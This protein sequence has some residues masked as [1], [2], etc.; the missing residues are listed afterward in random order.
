MKPI[1]H[2][3]AA[4]RVPPGTARGGGRRCGARLSGGALWCYGRSMG[5][6]SGLGQTQAGRGFPRA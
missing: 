2:E 3:G 6:F 1:R 5:T 4:R